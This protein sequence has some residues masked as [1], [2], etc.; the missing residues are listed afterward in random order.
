MKI[1]NFDTFIK[2]DVGSPFQVLSNDRKLTKEE[3]I[4]SIRLMVSAEYDAVK[5]Y[6]QLADSIDDELAIKVLKD[7]SEEELVHAGE[8]L[9]LLNIL[10]P[11]EE[12]LYKKGSKEVDKIDKL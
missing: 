2:E 12:K 6:T 9:K 11:E 4:R 8:F 3:L 5:M 1:K 7:I 10:E